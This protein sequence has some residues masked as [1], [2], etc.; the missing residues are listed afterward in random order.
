M[1]VGSSPTQIAWVEYC[2][3]A[4]PAVSHFPHQ[5]LGREVEGEAAQAVIS[6]IVIKQL[7]PAVRQAE[8]EIP[9]VPSL[10]SPVDPHSP[11]TGNWV[12]FT[13]TTEPVG[14]LTEAL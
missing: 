1:L 12:P 5:A 7:V 3:K 13:V 2:I 8:Y 6:G 11:A 14:P 9:S 10:Q 4:L